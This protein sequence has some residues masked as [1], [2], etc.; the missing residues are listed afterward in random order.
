M[1]LAEAIHAGPHL[2]PVPEWT[3][4]ITEEGEP[5]AAFLRGHQALAALAETAEGEVIAA[6]ASYSADLAAD[7]MEILDAAGGAVI[8]HDWMRM[9]AANDD[10]EF[11]EFCQQTANGAFPVTAVRFQ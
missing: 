6:F 3:V 7:V 8:R 10:A 4:L 11:F 1:N 9:T 2:G 5:H